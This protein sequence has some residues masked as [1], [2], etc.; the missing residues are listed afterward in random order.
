M[1]KTKRAA[2]YLRVSTDGQSVANQRLALEAVAG[3][4]KM[5]AEMRRFRRELRR[6]LERDAGHAAL[7]VAWMA[8]WGEVH[9]GSFAFD[10]P[11]EGRLTVWRSYQTTAN[12]GPHADSAQPASD[13]TCASH[14]LHQRPF[15]HI[16]RF[17]CL[18]T[19]ARFL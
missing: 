15:P 5:T 2:L 6:V 16:T 17:H 10:C 18:G 1:P 13:G 14:S 4:C 9:R 3:Q 7:N 12:A 19:G 8:S 11:P